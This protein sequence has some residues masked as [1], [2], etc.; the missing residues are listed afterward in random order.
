MQPDTS[1]PDEQLVSGYKWI[2]V[3]VMPRQDNFVAD[4]GY[5]INGDKDTSG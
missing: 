1:I 3:A 4:T 5:N 2:H